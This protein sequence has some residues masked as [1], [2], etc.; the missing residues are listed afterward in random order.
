MGIIKRITDSRNSLQVASW[1]REHAAASLI[2]CVVW[3]G[4]GGARQNSATWVAAKGLH[5]FCK[6]F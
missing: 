4:G 2:L 6:K 1:L 3:G 5:K